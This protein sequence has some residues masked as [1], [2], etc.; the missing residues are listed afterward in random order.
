MKELK[1]FFQYGLVLAI[2]L[3]LSAQMYGQEITFSS[4]S[5]QNNCGD[6]TN[7]N[8]NS[9]SGGC[10][11]P[12]TGGEVTCSGVGTLASGQASQF[13]MIVPT[14]TG[15]GAP[16]NYRLAAVGLN[17]IINSWG[18]DFQLNLRRPNGTYMNLLN[19]IGNS[20]SSNIPVNVTLCDTASRIYPATAG[21][22][23]GFYR[24][25]T[26]TVG[27]SSHLGGGQ[28]CNATPPINSSCSLFDF[29]PAGTNIGG[30]WDLVYTN[31]WGGETG[32]FTS[33]SMTFALP[34]A[35]PNYSG[36]T[37]LPLQA[38]TCTPAPVACATP[39]PAFAPATVPSSIAFV[40]AL[41]VSP[42]N[43]GTV[44]TTVVGAPG[45]RAVQYVILTGP[46]SAATV[47]CINMT[48]T[49]CPATGIVFT[50]PGL[51]HIL[52][53]SSLGCGAF[54]TSYQQINI[55]D[56]EPPTLVP[57][58]PTKPITLNAGPGECQVAWN[59]PPFMAMDN[60]PAGQYFGGLNRTGQICRL[61]NNWQI[62]GGAGAWGVMFDL[63]NTSGGQL[64]LQEVSWLPI[65]ANITHNI[66]YR[67]APGPHAPVQATASAWT[68]CASRVSDRGGQFSGLRDTFELVTGTAYDTLKACDPIIVD[69]TKVG[70]L[71]MAAGETR[72]I[73][74][75][76]PGQASSAI[77]IF[78][79]CNTG[80]FGDAN[81]NTPMHGATYTGG[82]FTAP[83]VNSS[84][85]F[86]NT[87]WM[88]HI[89][90]ALATSNRVRLVQTCGAPYGPGCFFPIGCTTLCYTA[91]DASGNVTNCTFDVCV[92]AYANPKKFVMQ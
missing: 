68:L 91:S 57:A 29:N 71:T 12:P 44:G 41:T 5:N 16:N 14:L 55:A 86:G 69:S 84:F 85:G 37:N 19:P 82:L 10:I 11:L 75:H 30:Q 22:I 79:D 26:G 59:A 52:W 31:G 27:T 47:P 33:W 20:S 35:L 32:Q 76:T 13:K 1:T 40:P 17:F 23:T 73:Y 6:V 51:K 92:N 78:N 36:V 60:C 38:G 64:N 74:I 70:C 45:G 56:L 7:P 34:E 39:A 65:A 90:Y 80:I 8:I 66:Y 61:T 21:A 87:N 53:R 83:F 49:P 25:K 54:D 2:F 3:S 43:G 88:G 42:Y 58:C 62:N 81:V 15:G 89:G 46:P 77:S 9:P 4:Q 67:T 24:P 63:V 28:N 50:T 18:G 72:G 48:M